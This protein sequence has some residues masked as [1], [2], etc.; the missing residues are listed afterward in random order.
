[1]P[2]RSLGAESVHLVLPS[3]PYARQHKK[4]GREGLTASWFGRTCEFM[5]VERI[6]TLDIHSREIEKLLW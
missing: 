3:Y 5:G 1:M 6:I 2:S 4:S